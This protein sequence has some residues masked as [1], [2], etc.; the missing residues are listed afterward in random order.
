MMASPSLPRPLLLCASLA[1]LLAGCGPLVQVGGNSHPPAELYTLSA[2]PPPSVPVGV[3][4][5]DMA[6]AVT[7]D[8]PS[9]PGAL[10]T[11]RIP[12][13]VSDTSIQYLV[14]AQWSEQPNRLFQR[15]LADRLTAGHVAVIDQRSSGQTGGRRLTGQLLAFGVDARAGRQVQVRYD[16][17]L[18]GRD[19]VRQRRFERSLPLSGIEGAEV[20]R[21]LNEVANA[22]AADVAL[23][24]SANAGVS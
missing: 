3:K 6:S 4:P 13:N 15:L 23:W 9:V 22:V 18:T 11:M 24:V 19:G 10:Q 12:V 1:A 7:V 14:G 8:I 16:A 20:A 21:A 5:L 2:P 17:T